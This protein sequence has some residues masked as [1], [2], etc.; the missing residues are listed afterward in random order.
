MNDRTLCWHLSESVKQAMEY[1]M[2]SGKAHEIVGESCL[3]GTTRYFDKVAE[4]AVVDYLAAHKIPCELV[5]EEIGHVSFGDEFI[6]YLDPIDGSNNAL[7]GLPFYCT[8]LGIM[9]DGSSYGLVRNLAWEEWYEGIS[10]YGSLYNGRPLEHTPSSCMISL[11]TKKG[12]YIEELQDYISKIR[13]LG[14]VALEVCYVAKGSLLAFID[15]RDK[16]RTTDIAAAKIVLESAGGVMTGLAGEP[17][18]LDENHV[19]IIAAYDAKVHAS[20]VRALRG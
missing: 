2:R 4:T 6:L 16:M 13:C 17:L 15:V 19:N 11:Y 18:D 5:S 10:E 14:S 8:S 1:A 9:R 12:K 3:G 7:Y 20:L